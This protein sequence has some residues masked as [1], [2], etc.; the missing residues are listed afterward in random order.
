IDWK[1]I[2]YKFEGKTNKYT[3]RLA[4]VLCII[5]HFT[6]EIN[7]TYHYDNISR[8]I[9]KIIN[10]D[11]KNAQIIGF[12]NI[13]AFEEMFPYKKRNSTYRRKNTIKNH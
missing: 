3:D 5:K 4:V 11:E 8:S 6:N 7:P 12:A 1:N 13:A 2:L 9:F 10:K